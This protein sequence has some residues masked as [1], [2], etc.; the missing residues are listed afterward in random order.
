MEI[1]L[2]YLKHSAFAKIHIIEIL[3][4]FI[5]FFYWLLQE[6]KLKTPKKSFYMNMRMI[7]HFLL[8]L[9]SIIFVYFYRYQYIKSKLKFEPT[10]GDLEIYYSEIESILYPFLFF[11]C[12]IFVIIF[13]IYIVLYI[14]EKQILS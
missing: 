11:Q 13:L 12:L 14:R 2:D 6:L 9:Y 3:I 4:I 1:Y 8:F 7:L 5:L 10:L